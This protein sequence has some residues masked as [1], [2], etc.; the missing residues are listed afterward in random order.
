MSKLTDV[1]APAIPGLVGTAGSLLNSNSANNYGDQTKW[2]PTG[3]N[4]PG[5]TLGYNN[6]TY[7]GTGNPTTQ[8]TANNLQ[9]AG[10]TLLSQYMQNQGQI[11]QFLQGEF[12]QSN[13]PN[14]NPYS[15]AG[16]NALGALGSYNPQDTANAYTGALRQSAL[17]NERNQATALIQQLLNSGRLGSTGGANQVGAQTTAFNEADL[18]RQIAGM[19]LGGQEQSRLAQMSMQ[20]G[21]TG[22]Q[23]TNQRFQNAM[24]MF[25]TGKAAEGQDLQSALSAAG[26]GM[27]G[28]NQET[29]TALNAVG[30]SGRLSAE[31][32]AANTAA[33]RPGLE[34]DVATN[35]NITSGLADIIGSIPGLGGTA[36]SGLGGLSDLLGLGGT[37][38]NAAG[39]LSG[40][41]SA[42]GIGAGALGTA[43]GAG[44]GIGQGLGTGGLLGQSATAESLFGGFGGVAPGAGAAAP[45]AG[46][47]G[48]LM[49]ALG[50]ALA[51]A[52]VMLAPSV[53]NGKPNNVQ[54]SNAAQQAGITVSPD[55]RTGTI[56]N[57]SIELSKKGS[58]SN[59]VY[60]TDQNGKQLYDNTFQKVGVVKPENLYKS[61][62]K[63]GATNLPSLEEFKATYKKLYN[64]DYMHN[65]NNGD[66][67][68]QFARTSGTANTQ[69]VSGGTK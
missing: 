20:L 55:G 50:P 17:P 15:V 39:G 29:N 66:K 19:Q 11:P 28:A 23:M 2:A 37:A 4:I 14:A 30:T 65:Y 38:A 5:L 67:D 22:N 21:Q 1:L 31:Q 49:A 12:N 27:N 18:Q 41:G 47:G 69:P 16:T 45:A 34:A 53:L 56:G 6:G 52:G 64:Q 8:A 26:L 9:G 48:S 62:K 10:N 59:A 24:N 25:Q 58:M 60:W 61:F 33:Y 44:L 13:D 68:S 43:G 57:M 54:Y 36:G 32:S 63:Q 35:N 51:A 46:A 3:L 40:L 42:L 7:T